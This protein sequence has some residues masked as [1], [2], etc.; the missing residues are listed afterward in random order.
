MSIHGQ[1]KDSLSESLDSFFFVLVVTSFFLLY[2]TESSN[3]TYWVNWPNESKITPFY[4]VSWYTLIWIM[5]YELSIK[6]TN[7]WKHCTYI[8]Y[9]TKLWLTWLVCNVI[10]L[11]TCNILLIGCNVKHLMCP[12]FKTCYKIIFLHTKLH[13]FS[14]ECGLGAVILKF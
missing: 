10:Y 8:V 9:I 11:V 4:W 2:F 6:F 5:M 14:L 7:I 13:W 12:Y 1:T 3:H